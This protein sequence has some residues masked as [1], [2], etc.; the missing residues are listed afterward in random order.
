MFTYDVDLGYGLPAPAYRATA[1]WY[2]VPLPVYRTAAW[3]GGSAGGWRIVA[4]IGTDGGLFT[5]TADTLA[6]LRDIC[7]N[8]GIRIN[9]IGKAGA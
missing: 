1:A 9:R 8:Y 6:G 7:S 3:S 4:P 2:P 5:L